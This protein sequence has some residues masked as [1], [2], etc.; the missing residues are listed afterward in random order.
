MWSKCCWSGGYKINTLL[1]EEV[2][3]KEKDTWSHDFIGGENDT[4]NIRYKVRSSE[5]VVEIRC[6]KRSLRGRSH[7]KKP[8]C[9]IEYLHG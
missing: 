4:G 6:R 7:L 3:V 9:W 8:E 5:W 2:V 1:V